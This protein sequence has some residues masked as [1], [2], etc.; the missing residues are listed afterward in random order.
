[1]TAD[2]AGAVERTPDAARRPPRGLVLL[3]LFVLFI[4]WSNS[5]HAI[6]YFRRE[7]GVSS[8]SLVMLRYGPAAPFCL[9]WC[10]WRWRATR[11]LL[12]RHFGRLLLM[13]LC[14]IPGYNYA[15]NWGQLRV[16]ADTASLLIATNPVFTLLLALLFLREQ[17]RATR[18]AGTAIAFLGVYLLVQ[19]QRAAYGPTYLPYALVVLLAPLCWA[20]ATVTGKSISD[21]V[22]P[23]LLTFTATALGSLPFLVGLVAGLE[24]THATLAGLDALGWVALA[25]LTILCTIVG[26][27]VW[28]WA[29][30]WL[31]ASTAAAFVFLNPPL[32]A[33]FGYI[34][35]TERFHWSTA[36]YGGV[37]MAGVALSVGLLRRA[38]R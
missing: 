1:M 19:A 17:A 11:E 3:A 13:A 15:L 34:W 36:V 2:R 24:G 10:L 8:G 32:T 38:R 28:F 27:A 30:R 7:L 23:L 16:A 25:H 35:G 14:M 18:L 12:A 21:R 29:L 20:I 33:L 22:D 5:F 6:A 31:Q 9:A 26:F 4:L 37:T